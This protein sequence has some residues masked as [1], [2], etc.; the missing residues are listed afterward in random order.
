[1]RNLLFLLFALYGVSV[2]TV[3]AY[4]LIALDMPALEQAVATKAKN[5]EIRH[6]I[7]VF[8]EGN[9]ILFGNIIT[10]VS[11]G[12]MRSRHGKEDCQD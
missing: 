9:W 6:R 7:N 1:M 5:A 11:L 10:I 8:A 3:S 12:C 4:G 2:S